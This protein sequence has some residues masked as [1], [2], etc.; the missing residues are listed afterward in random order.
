MNKKY[1][2][3]STIKARGWT[4]GMVSEFLGDPD[5][6]RPN[7]H[8][9]CAA[10]MRRYDLARVERVEKRKKV[11]AA[12]AAT[13]A[14]RGARKA[15]A[16]K[17]VETKAAATLSHFE[18]IPAPTVPVLDRAE[19]IRRACDSY[20][21]RRAGF[22]TRRSVDAPDANTSCDEDFLARIC[23]NYLR[24]NLTRYDAHLSELFA[25]VGQ[26]EAYVLLKGRVLDA[27]ATAYDW[28][29]EE[30]ESQRIRSMWRD[31]PLLR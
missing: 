19:L 30:C 12:L 3:K 17:G 26:N 18:A 13:A 7:P 27:I 9:S 14:Q 5:L 16:A 15:A 6:E 8:Y 29:A 22:D 28:L 23:V 31:R 21:A 1:V 24:H 4:D 20:N 10:P 25:R 2:T 11:R